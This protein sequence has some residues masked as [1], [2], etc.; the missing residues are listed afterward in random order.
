MADRADFI[1]LFFRFKGRVN[2]AAYSLSFLF[3]LMVVSFPLYQYMRVMP[4]IDVADMAEMADVPLSAAAQLWSTVFLFVLIAF[5]WGHI[6]TSI[7]RLHDIG[8]PGIMVLSLFIP[9]VSIV[10]FVA[11]CIWPGDAGPNRYG[12][13]SNAAG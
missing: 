7:K 1:W 8:K 2:R 10:A 5:L 6:A 9:V 3:M 12:Q 11:L 13:R 4:D